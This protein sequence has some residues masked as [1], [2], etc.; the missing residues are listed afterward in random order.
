VRGGAGRTT[1][2]EFDWLCGVRGWAESGVFLLEKGTFFV[3]KLDTK[4]GVLRC[5]VADCFWVRR[6]RRS[7]G[8]SGSIGSFDR[9]VSRRSAFDPWCAI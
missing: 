6:V 2:A 5:E 3:E 8:R 9:F 7:D 1:L 4:F